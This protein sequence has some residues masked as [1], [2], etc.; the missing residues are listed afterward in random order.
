[1]HLPKLAAAAAFFSVTLIALPPFT[2][3]SPQSSVRQEHK[4]EAPKARKARKA[5]ELCDVMGQ[6]AVIQKSTEATAELL[7]KMNVPESFKKAYLERFDYDYFINMFV[8]IYTEKLEEETIDALIAFYST[9]QGKI[10]AAAT[11]ELTVE[12]MRRGQAYGEALM[13]DIMNGK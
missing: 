6:R 7:D 2:E 13:R 4:E 12:G 1:M 3:L 9:E 5:K 8:D 10:Y 11:P